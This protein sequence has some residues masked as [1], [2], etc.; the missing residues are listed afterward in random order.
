MECKYLSVIYSSCNSPVTVRPAAYGHTVILH[1]GENKQESQ[2]KFTF[3][4]LPK[5]VR[6]FANVNLYT[7][8]FNKVAEFSQNLLNF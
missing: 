4:K 7:N 6:N 2:S 3:V 5:T 1:K 8:Q